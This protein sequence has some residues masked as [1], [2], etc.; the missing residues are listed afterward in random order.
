VWSA[1]I[2]SVRNAPMAVMD[3][4][5]VQAYGLYLRWKVLTS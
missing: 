3:G 2:A 4:I 1:L 5:A